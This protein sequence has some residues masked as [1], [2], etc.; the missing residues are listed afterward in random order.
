[1]QKPGLRRNRV[2]WAAHPPL[3]LVSNN[4]IK[5][6][7]IIGLATALPTTLELGN[8]KGVLFG[9]SCLRQRRT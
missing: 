5:E 1:M 8:L 9:G 4:I 2:G 3:L 7:K 6:Y